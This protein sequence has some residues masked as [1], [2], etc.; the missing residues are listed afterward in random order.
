[1]A[2]LMSQRAVVAEEISVIEGRGARHRLG[3]YRVCVTDDHGQLEGLP[4][5]FCGLWR[6][7]YYLFR[8]IGRLEDLARRSVIWRPV[9]PG[10]T[11]RQV[12]RRG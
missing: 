4:P 3:N 7:S 8:R 10:Q 9:P 5:D 6:R 1:M 2:W 12:A 11:L